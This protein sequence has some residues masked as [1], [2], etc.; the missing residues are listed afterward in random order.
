M[1]LRTGRV[2][3]PSHLG[4]FPVPVRVKRQGSAPG[5]RPGSRDLR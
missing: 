5:Q 2:T 3:G 4:W 1:D